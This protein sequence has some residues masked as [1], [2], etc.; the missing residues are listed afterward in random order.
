MSLT[1]AF[2]VYGT[3]ID[4]RGVTNTLQQLI[5]H[6]AVAFAEQ[7]RSKQLEY[8]FR[9]GLMGA[10]QDF[11][12]CTAQALAHTCE[13]MDVTITEE[14]RESLMTGYRQLPAFDD[15]LAALRRLQ[16]F[17]YRMFAFSNGRADD[18]DALLIHSG[19]R[20]FFEDVVSVDEVESFKPDPLV[21]R[22][23][24]QRT[25]AEA[26]STW[27]VS[28]NPFDLLG[29]AACGFSTAWVR[30]N[31]GVPFDPW[32]SEPNVTIATLDEL[33]DALVV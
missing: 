14:D 6:R 28:G 10:Y 12:V 22:H 4:T 15:A 29:A 30:R 32:G 13:L 23:F 16:P 3:L 31:P 26:D 20:S 27:L 7:W 19:I 21:Y 8:S 9:R 11:S 1:L 18:V 33:V 24:L 17:E 25:G 2:D 5:G